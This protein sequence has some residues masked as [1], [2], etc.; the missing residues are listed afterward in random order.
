[1]SR[2]HP[3]EA[4]RVPEQHECGRK[5]R[6]FGA[7]ARV[8]CVH[9]LLLV[10]CVIVCRGSVV[11]GSLVVSSCVESSTAR[12]SVLQCVAVCCSVL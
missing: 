7:C 6:V 1:M 5:I 10:L 11:V 4:K 2:C 9:A 12:C 8:S 3:V